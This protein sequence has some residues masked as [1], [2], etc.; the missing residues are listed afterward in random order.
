MMNTQIEGD[1]LDVDAIREQFPILKQKINGHPLIYLDNASICQKPQSVINSI[2]L[3]YSEFYANPHCGVHTLS[4]RAMLAV[5]QVR[6][7]VRTFLHARSVDEIIF[8]HGTID[9]INL[10]AGSWGITYLQAGDEVLISAL[11]HHS[12]IVPWQQLCQKTGAHLKILRINRYGVLQPGFLEQ[13]LSHRTRIVALPHMSNVPDTVNPLVAIIK[14]VRAY[15]ERCHDKKE[16]TVVLIDGAQAVSHIVVNVQDLDADFYT[17]SSHKLYGPGGIGVLY[18]RGGIPRDM[19]SWQNGSGMV[20]EASFEQMTFI[21]PPRR[22]ESDTINIADIIGLGAALTWLQSIGIES[23]FRHEKILLDYATQQLSLL[24]HIRILG[25]SPLKSAVV[26]FIIEN[27]PARTIGL[28]LDKA[29]IAVQVGRHCAQPLM[30]FFG[31]QETVR[32]SF[33]VYNTLEDVDFL[34]SVLN[35]II[36]KCYLY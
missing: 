29:G 27:I 31:V 5:E 12:N 2:M 30:T 34:I 10:L 25:Q 20:A 14:A 19:P 13:L 36:K 9:V 33:A 32:I 7:Q 16:K 6:E 21:V 28:A 4:Q 18:C 22:F 35:N 15:D 11:E 8:T 17:F 3:F 24:P 26:T 23:I 1:A